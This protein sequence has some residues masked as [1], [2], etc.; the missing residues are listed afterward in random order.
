MRTDGRSISYPLHSAVQHGDAN[1]VGVLLR[2]GAD[3]NA[4]YTDHYENERGFN[5][6]RVLSP[7]HLASGPVAQSRKRQQAL[8]IVIVLLAEGADP[9]EVATWIDHVDS[10]ERGATDDPREE[11]FVPS[12]RCVPVRETAL[13]RALNAR[14][15]ELVRA[16]L[17][18]GADKSIERIRDNERESTEAMAARLDDETGSLAAALRTT[19][20]WSPENHKFYSQRLKEQVRT[21]LLVAKAS[22]WVLPEDALH[23]IFLAL[24]V[25]SASAAP[26]LSQVPPRAAET[27]TGQDNAT[28]EMP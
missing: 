25:Q 22:S 28:G 17:A 23:A 21:I 19:A 2:A 14:Q 6:H 7:L 10:G 5:Q 24:S 9:N 12:V 15:P 20:G 4:P 3:V 16:L 8:D 27:E 26:P 13:H 18:A 1:I 11:G